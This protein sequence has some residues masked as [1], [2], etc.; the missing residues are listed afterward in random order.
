MLAWAKGS[1][2]DDA[3][4][5]LPAWNDRRPRDVFVYFDVKVRAPFDA[6]ALRDRVDPLLRQD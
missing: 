1:E 4:R 3:Q 2:P 6:L 5:V